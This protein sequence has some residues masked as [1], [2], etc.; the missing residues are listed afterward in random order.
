[1]AVVLQKTI[2]LNQAIICMLELFYLTD[3]LVIVFFPRLLESV[4]AA[5]DRRLSLGSNFS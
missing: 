1:M 3:C 2:L 5:F 4:L